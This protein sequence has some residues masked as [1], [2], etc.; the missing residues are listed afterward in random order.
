MFYITA[1]SDELYCNVRELTEDQSDCGPLE[2][3]GMWEWNAKDV[4]W[5]ADGDIQN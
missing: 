1:T 3:M 2:H 5:T 4:P